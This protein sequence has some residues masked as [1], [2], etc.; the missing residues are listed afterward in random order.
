MDW[1]GIVACLVV[2]VYQGVTNYLDRK[3]WEKERSDLL[4]RIMS[5]NYAVYVQGELAKKQADKPMT[6]DELDE[7]RDILPVN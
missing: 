5:T 2:I 3:G 1:I 7:Y 4:N 6:D